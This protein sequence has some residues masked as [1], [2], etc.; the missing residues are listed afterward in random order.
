MSITIPQKKSLEQAMVRKSNLP[1]QN[2][3]KESANACCI[4][5]N[6]MSKQ[7]WK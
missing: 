2:S 1:L 4:G 7:G 3:V 5:G 6:R